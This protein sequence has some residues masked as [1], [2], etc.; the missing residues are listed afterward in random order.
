MRQF[1]LLILS[2]MTLLPKAQEVEVSGATS[3]R[4]GDR[5]RLLVYADQFSMLEKTI[6]ETFSNSEGK[7]SL[8]AKIPEP[9]YGFLALNME[10]GEFYLHP[11][12][13]YTFDIPLPEDVSKGS[14]FDKIPLQFS[15]EARNDA[16]LQSDIGL[17]NQLFNHFI[18]E[19]A[20]AIYRSRSKKVIEDFKGEMQTRFKQSNNEYFQNYMRYAFIS[21]DWLSKRMSDSKVIEEFVSNPLLYQNI[22]YTEFFKTFFDNYLELMANKHYDEMIYLLNQPSGFGELQSFIEQDTLLSSNRQVSELVMMLLMS[23][24]YYV[25]D[26]QKVLILKKFRLLSVKS[27]Y[28]Q[29]RAIALHF[30][31][32][33]TQLDYGFPAP[34]FVLPSPD[35]DSVSLTSYGGKFVLLGFVR[36]DCQI[37]VSDLEKIKK[38]QEQLAD[39]LSIIT[40]VVGPS[41]GPSKPIS[42][43]SDYNWEFLSISKTSLLPQMYHVRTY[44]TYVLINPDGTVAYATMPMPDENMELMISRFIARFSQQ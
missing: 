14:I 10:K 26:I 35:G 22:Q 15:I 38:I 19:N 42:I 7:F 34:D 6:A 23:K 30:I 8:T 27:T 21:L 28:V 20:Q 24:F 9:T 17:F 12:A 41:N 32:K 11:G 25:A 44:P 37:C 31:E 1:I 13:T 18:Y 5:V 36:F 16:G 40:L 33:L 29:N 3:G 39:K 4:N 2:F 43:Q